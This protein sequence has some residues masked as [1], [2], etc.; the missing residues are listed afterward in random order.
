MKFLLAA[1]TVA[2]LIAA[3]G[4]KRN[5][6]RCLE[7]LC[8]DPDLPFCDVDGTIGGEPNAC[9]AVDCTP[10][11]VA[12]C[13]DDRALTCNTAGTNYDLVDCP[14]G[15]DAGGCKPCNS[16]ECEKHIIPRYLP[17]VCD[18]LWPGDPVTISADASIDTT[19]SL[20]CSDVVAQA[21]GVDICVLR[22]STLT[23]A[24]NKVLTVVG[25]RAVALVADRDL[26][27]DGILDVSANATTSGPGGG[28]VKSGACVGMVGGGGGAGYRTTGGSGG[29]SAGAGNGGTVAANPP[30]VVDLRGG[31]N[32]IATNCLPG[33]G[34][35]ALTL[36]SCRGTVSVS[37]LIDAGG[38][39][40]EGN[41]KDVLPDAPTRQSGGGGSGGTVVLQGMSIDATGQFYA[42]GGGG[43]GI[44]FSTCV[45][46]CQFGGRG[47]DGLRSTGAA[48]GGS[49]TGV[50]GRGGSGTTTP[51]NGQAV[52]AGSED[53]SGG[54]GSAGFF[55][56]YTPN[57]ITPVISPL[58]A[59]PPF[60]PNGTIPT[61]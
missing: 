10:G 34:G 52:S 39:G 56:S 47:A 20:N 41:F 35:G 60:L 33:G 3:C 50:G 22:Y 61:N 48:A 46:S 27:V 1:A 51:T 24:T 14:Y 54:G 2:A 23:I 5:E 36:V 17:S 40:G 25:S 29:G 11:E 13:R 4:T 9:I 49:G 44:K 31:T 26:K 12:S 58:A 59:S 43:G 16:T 6:E 32:A 15:C 28:V 53:G 42:N 30:T 18:E 57:G 38:G 8:S 19:N 37:G 7:G 21:G 55:V 45:P